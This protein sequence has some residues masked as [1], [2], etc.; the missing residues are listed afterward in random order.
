MF[1]KKKM[2]P[3]CECLKKNILSSATEYPDKNVDQWSFQFK[4]IAIADWFQGK[5]SF[6]GRRLSKDL[7]RSVEADS[8]NRHLGVNSVN[9]LQQSFWNNAVAK[10]AKGLTEM[11]D[12]KENP[13]NL[14][15]VLTYIM[16][17]QSFT[18]KKIAYWTKNHS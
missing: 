4:E 10:G 13:E 2:S 5:D 17:I 7:L 15:D 12:A 6:Q 9:S 1:C 8:S 3:A 16:L 18:T 11:T 14:F